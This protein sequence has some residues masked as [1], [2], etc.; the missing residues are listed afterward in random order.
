MD[1]WNRTVPEKL[2]SDRVPSENSRCRE[3]QQ[4][5]HGGSALKLPIG[6]NGLT[7]P[8]DMNITITYGGVPQPSPG[9]RD[10]KSPMVR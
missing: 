1:L 7:L 6:D 3:P 9:T 10:N 2:P 5:A 8:F 4:S